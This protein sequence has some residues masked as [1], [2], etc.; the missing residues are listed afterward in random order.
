MN[1]LLVEGLHITV[2]GLGVVFAGLSLLIVFLL[3]INLFF[4]RNGRQ[5]RHMRTVD[6]SPGE[7]DGNTVKS[8]PTEG[9]LVA[10]VVACLAYMEASS[11]S[12]T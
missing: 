7:A 8:D 10:A 1:R 5:V 6:V 11:D 12:I 9:E 3:L 4:D 2:L